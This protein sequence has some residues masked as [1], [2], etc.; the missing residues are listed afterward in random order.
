MQ[1]LAN[2][3]SDAQSS[4]LTLTQKPYKTFAASFQIKIH[5]IGTITV[6]CNK[7]L[8]GTEIPSCRLADAS[9]DA[10]YGRHKRL[11]MLLF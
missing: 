11:N 7:V 10:G 9:D 5:S 1:S 8:R 2:A 4:Q 6:A 3:L